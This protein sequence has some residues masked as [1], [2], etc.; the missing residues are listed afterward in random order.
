MI[1][2][3]IMEAEQEAKRFLKRVKEY[4]ES[5]SY[6]PDKRGYSYFYSAERAA[7]KRS[8][9]DLTKSLSKMRNRDE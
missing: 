4:K 1:D 3:N 5:D 7:I 9:M 2:K 6:G 8:S